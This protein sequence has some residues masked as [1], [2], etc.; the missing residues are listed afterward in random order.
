VRNHAVVKQASLVV[1]ATDGA[2]IIFTFC[3]IIPP[4]TAKNQ[5]KGLIFNNLVN[6]IF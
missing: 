4:K 6:L 2:F 1:S 5:A 3:I